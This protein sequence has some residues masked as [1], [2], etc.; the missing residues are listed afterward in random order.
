M[1]DENAMM[2]ISATRRE[3]A[4]QPEAVA[5]VLRSLRGQIQDLAKTL[6]QRG[7]TQVLASGSGDSWFAAQAV[8]L[9]WERYAGLRYEALQ[10]Y[11]YAAYGLHGEDAQTAHI[12]I[13]SS[14]RPTTT[15]DALDRALAGPAFVIGITDKEFAENPFATRPPVS[16]I[17][18]AVKVG[19]PAQ[20]TT[21]T[22]AVLLDLAITTGAL[23]GTLD[24][25]QADELRGELVAMPERM[26]T[27]L[28]KATPWAEA[29]APSLAGKRLYTFVGAG[30][31]YAIAQNGAALMAEGPQE[32]G[33]A[34]TVEEFH[35]GL[36]IGT[37]QAGD[38]IVLIAP[39]GAAE[40]RYRDTARVVRAWGAR[41]IPLV[42]AD[43]TDLLGDDGDGF[44]V[45]DAPEELT[46]LLMVLPLHALSIALAAHKVAG[47]YQRPE[48]VPS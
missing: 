40:T 37:Y 45:P 44:I 43:T 38:P 21:A 48:S 31:G 13:S 36:R 14:G 9:A 35:H 26:E 47:G 7:V 15:W 34:L 6:V 27:V 23:N 11:E 30:P 3:V 17:P 20:T 1:S 19:W 5:R 39:A 16:L 22:M 18:G 41:L 28:A 25:A 33:F 2:P 32:V 46:P 4:D 10:A 24:A 8:R 29:L 12:I 42:T